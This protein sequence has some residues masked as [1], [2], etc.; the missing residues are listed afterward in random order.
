M[1]DDIVAG[2]PERKTYKFPSQAEITALRARLA[3]VE[4]EREAEMLR[5]KACEHIA[6]GDEGWEQLRNECPSTAAVAGLRDRL[7]EVERHREAI[8]DSF[9]EYQHRAQTE[10][11][12]L[13]AQLRAYTET[14][15]MRPFKWLALQD[16]DPVPMPEPESLDGLLRDAARAQALAAALERLIDTYEALFANDPSGA[17]VRFE[18][19]MTDAKAALAA[20]RGPA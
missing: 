10:H 9:K 6:E 16:A 19:A 20:A 8:L 1:S 14:V 17:A 2:W 11:S 15:V 18:A 4:R 13:K 7:A 12:R 5:L 3:E